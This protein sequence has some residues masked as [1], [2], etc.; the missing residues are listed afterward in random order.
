[1]SRIQA[2]TDTGGD[3]EARRVLRQVHDRLPQ[4]ISSKLVQARQAFEKGPRLLAE[5]LRRR[6]EPAAVGLEKERLAARGRSARLVPVVLPL[7]H[8]PPHARRRPPPDQALEN[9]P[10][11]CPAGAGEL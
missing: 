11:P 6:C 4:G 7:L 3:A 1:R 5:F 8:G 9:D 2:P 10:P